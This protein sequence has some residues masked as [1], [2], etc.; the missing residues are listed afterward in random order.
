MR[1]AVGV[2]LQ[3]QL[4]GK[5]LPGDGAGFQPVVGHGQQ[6]QRLVVAVQQRQQVRR[7][8][9]GGAIERPHGQRLLGRVQCL[10]VAVLELQELRLADLDPRRLW[11]NFGR[12]REPRLGRVEIAEHARHFADQGVP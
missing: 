4:Q 3:L 11:A 9:H 1:P 5:E 8:L 7:R 2:L 6:L 12:P 10:V